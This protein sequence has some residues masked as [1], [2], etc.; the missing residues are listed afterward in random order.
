MLAF[1]SRNWST[2]PSQ[3]EV[4]NLTATSG[5]IIFPYSLPW[6]HHLPYSCDI[7][8]T[9]SAE[10]SPL[11]GK[12]VMFFSPQTWCA[13]TP[14]PEL[15][16]ELSV[17]EFNREANLWDSNTSKRATLLLFEHEWTGKANVCGLDLSHSNQA[18]S[19][20]LKRCTHISDAT[21]MAS[22]TFFCP[23]TKILRPSYALPVLLIKHSFVM[24]GSVLLH[25]CC[26]GVWNEEFT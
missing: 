21:A 2:H 9:T 12:W 8:T 6:M 7:S 15:T 19:H 23:N 1:K 14:K 17:S 18:H 4:G 26:S 5:K 13:P 11:F 16:S 25:L 24:C 22:V 10:R 20:K 3:A